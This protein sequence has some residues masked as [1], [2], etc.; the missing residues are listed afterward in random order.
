MAQT[1]FNANPSKFRET[2][3]GRT[4]EQFIA[5][6][7]SQPNFKIIYMMSEGDKRELYRLSIQ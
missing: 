6:L 2:A 7:Q 3:K 1:L 5:Y 4:Y